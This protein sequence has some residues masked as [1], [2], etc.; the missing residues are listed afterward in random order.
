MRRLRCRVS[1]A[2]TLRLFGV[3]GRELT[4]SAKRESIARKSHMVKKVWCIALT[5]RM[6]RPMDSINMGKFDLANADG[7]FL[8][9]SGFHT[10]A[11]GKL[12]RCNIS[13]AKLE[14]SGAKLGEYCGVRQF[15]ATENSFC[16]RSLR[17]GARKTKK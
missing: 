11:I 9:I 14:R 17:R 5:S 1:T 15:C 6:C 16:R 13:W 7:R 4:S 10:W 3:S 12:E 8:F 2:T